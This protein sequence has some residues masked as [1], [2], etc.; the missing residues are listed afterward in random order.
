MKIA[1]PM[2]ASDHG[3]ARNWADAVLKFGGLGAHS[4]SFIPTIEARA[5][6]EE[7]SERF[8]AANI[9]N[10]ILTMELIPMGG[11]PKGPNVQFYETARLM[12][13]QQLPWLWMEL[14][15]LPVRTGWADQIAA[16]YTSRNTPFMGHIIQTPW[17]NTE[18]GESVPSPEGDG[19]TM[20]CGVGVYPAYFFRMENAKPLFAD[21]AKGPD[22]PDDGFDIY[23]RTVIRI[24]GMSDSASFDDKW[25]TINYRV[26]NGV[27]TCDHNPKHPGLNP[28]WAPLKRGGPISKSAAIVHGCKDNTLFDLIMGG[29]DL[30]RQ[31]PVTLTQSTETALSGQLSAT[32]PLPANDEVAKLKD[33]LAELKAM[34]RQAL[35]TNPAG[36]AAANAAPPDSS[37]SPATGHSG[38]KVA[39][40][41][42]CVAPGSAKPDTGDPL[43][44]LV[45]LLEASSKKLRLDQ[46]A[47]QL[48]IPQNKL[49]KLISKD[50]SPVQ[51]GKLGWLTLVKAEV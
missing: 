7:I 44:K 38:E 47:R 39:D 10:E 11:W 27:L 32:P 41:S 16:E 4:F 48:G 36:Q 35:T 17:R 3:K 22:A 2:S 26:E 13:N 29:L 34:L 33:E 51:K 49:D 50:D 14:D 20:M 8:T 40:G 31:I 9:Q 42:R 45:S 21:F 25:N 30:S 46:A 6:A 12:S 19:D 43:S 5:I 15:V 24:A 37:V 18:T 1:V 28:N 23:L